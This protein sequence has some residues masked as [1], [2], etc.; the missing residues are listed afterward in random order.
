MGDVGTVLIIA[1][2]DT[3][4]REVL[5]LGECFKECG[6]PVVLLDA[7][8]MGESPFPVTVTREEIALAGGM[9][10]A[11]VRNLGSEGD[12]LDVMIQGAI[13]H[14][15]DL[16][17]KGK[18]KGI[19]GIGGSMGTTLGTGVMRAF[20]VGFPKVMLHS[21]CDLSGINRI[22]GKILRNGAFAI[23]GM[24]KD[25]AGF[26]LS[27][28]PLIVLTTLGTT[29]GCAKMVRQALEDMGKEVVVFHTVGSG[30]EA[31][32]EF[33]RE[34]NVE[35]LIDLSLHELMDHYFEGDYDA[36]PE[37]GVAALEKGVPTILIPG[38]IDFLVT[39]PLNTAKERFPGRPYHTHNA[40]ITAVRTKK[41]EMESIGIK[42]AGF[43]DRAKGAVS[44]VVPVKGFSVW[45]RKDGPFYNPDGV[46][47]FVK[48]LKDGLPSN[49]PLHLLPYHINDPEFARSLL[50][51]LHDMIEKRRL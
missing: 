27:A 37:R 36:G 5:Y 30:G 24:V 51:I 9:T 33:I 6:T 13:K 46:D 21:V 34:E 40:A 1:T 35:A 8:I 42:L 45:D 41:E 19:I 50:E 31:M 22:T 25:T 48:S 15:K 38:N 23:A 12:A 3:K 49:V 18:I 29:E 44:V 14:A 4:S 10:L 32:E 28:K 47:A 2:M 11:D 43:C 17:L 7:G 20:P 26:S 39:G 16:Y